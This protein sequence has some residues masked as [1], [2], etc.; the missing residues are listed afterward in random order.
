METRPVTAEAGFLL[1]AS[2]SE[3]ATR[4]RGEME[5]ALTT[6]AVLLPASTLLLLGLSNRFLAIAGV[7]RELRERYRAAPDESLLHQIRNLRARCK[8]MRASQATGMASLGLTVMA[9]LLVF[10]GV[11]YIGRW[12]FGVALILLIISL[13]LALVEIMVSVD[14]IELEIRDL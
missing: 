6:P 7:L 12:V 5:I 13:V 8:V 10:V 11:E 2:V 4:G 14:A 3:Q 1:P 9:M